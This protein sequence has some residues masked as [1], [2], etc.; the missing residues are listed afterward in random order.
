MQKRASLAFA[1]KDSEYKSYCS[2]NS[3]LKQEVLESLENVDSISQERQRRFIIALQDFFSQNKKDLDFIKFHT[4]FKQY[5]CEQNKH[6]VDLIPNCEKWV[7]KDL[8]SSCFY[9]DVA[10]SLFGTNDPGMQEKA[11]YLDDSQINDEKRVELI[12]KLQNLQKSKKE[13]EHNAIEK[14]QPQDWKKWFK[15]INTLVS[16]VTGVVLAA[17]AL[18]REEAIKSGVEKLLGAHESNNL[19]QHAIDLPQHTDL[20]HHAVGH[21]TQHTDLSHHA[22][23]HLTEYIT[24]SAEVHQCAFDKI[25]PGLAGLI[26]GARVGADIAAASSDADDKDTVRLKGGAM[27][28]AT[29]IAATAGL[30]ALHGLPV[31]APVIAGA[32]MG[33]SIADKFLA[34]ESDDDKTKLYKKLAG[35][36]VGAV[37]FPATVAAIGA[38]LAT[39]GVVAATPLVVTCIGLGVAGAIIYKTYQDCPHTSSQPLATIRPEGV[40]GAVCQEKREEG[41]SI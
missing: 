39:A 26:L 8:G 28:G 18:A 32:S 25:I 23:G 36:T 2:V 37:A 34:S 13:Q 10:K 14:S 9:Q 11:K 27:G 1:I 38:G 41:I 19:A 16:S 35:A 40:V 30:V 33:Y 4:D 29:A 7:A 6:L 15:P 5:L 24:G 12:K 31:V 20:S 3:A 17:E 22:A 21:L